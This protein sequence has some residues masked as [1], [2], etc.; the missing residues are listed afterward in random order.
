M[1]KLKMI[2]AALL[3]ALPAAPALA[4][5][6]ASQSVYSDDETAEPTHFI[7]C[8]HDG[9]QIAFILE[10]SPKVVHGE[11]VI[12]IVDGDN[13][14]EYNHEVVHKYILGKP[15][16][17]GIGQVENR[18]DEI[19]GELNYRAGDVILSGFE[20]ALPVRVNDLNGKTVYSGE[21]DVHGG[22]TVSLSQYPAGV[23]LLTVQ[24]KTFKFIKR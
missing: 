2:V 9:Q 10:H 3:L 21:T 1:K 15:T 4:C 6:A 20:A 5:S 13:A 16:E 12:T 14:L 23:Y 11:G 19:S 18:T 22:L 17:T 8:L 24:H 7:L